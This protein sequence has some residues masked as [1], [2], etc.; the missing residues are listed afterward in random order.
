MKVI[1]GKSGRRQPMQAQHPGYMRDTQQDLPYG[2]CPVCGQMLYRGN[3]P[4]CRRCEGGED[5]GT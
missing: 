5:Y 3:G 2:W 1:F 4:L